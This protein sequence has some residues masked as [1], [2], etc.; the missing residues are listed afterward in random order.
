M[1]GQIR[2]GSSVPGRS[3]HP[4]T[5]FSTFS[6]NLIEMASKVASVQDLVGIGDGPEKVPTVGQNRSDI[7]DGRSCHLDRFKGIVKGKLATDGLVPLYGKVS[8]LECILH[9]RWWGW[10]VYAKGI[11]DYKLAVESRIQLLVPIT[12][13]V[14]RDL[15]NV[16]T[17]IIK[18]K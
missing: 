17:Q 11:H 5:D 15:G 2:C 7:L 3:C 6:Y 14:D 8:G 18:S 13:M 9:I 4:P 12:G 1:V 16:Y 10:C